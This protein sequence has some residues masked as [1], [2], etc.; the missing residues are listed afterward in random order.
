M[1]RPKA[2]FQVRARFR[3]RPNLQ[4]LYIPP[5]RKVPGS[6]PGGE[7]FAFRFLYGKR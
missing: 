5:V 7:V 6:K 2:M 1:G 3:V 4:Q